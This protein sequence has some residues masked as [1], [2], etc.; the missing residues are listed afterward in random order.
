ML[1]RFFK[2]QPR[3]HALGFS[4]FNITERQ[5]MAV[6][7]SESSDLSGLFF[8]LMVY[9]EAAIA[10][11]SCFVVFE[12]NYPH[13]WRALTRLTNPFLQDIREKGGLYGFA[14]QC[15]EET[16][17]PAARD[18][19]PTWCPWHRCRPCRPSPNPDKNGQ[20]TCATPIGTSKMFFNSLPPKALH[21]PTPSR[22]R[23]FTHLSVHIYGGHSQQTPVP[24]RRRA[25][26]VI[27]MPPSSSLSHSCPFVVQNLPGIPRR[28]A[29]LCVLCVLCGYLSL[30][31]DLNPEP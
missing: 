5:S 28:P 27:A 30:S 24:N 29:V 8:R 14:V 13:T 4:P 11:S 21:R 25:G 23:P 26:D 20:Y 2:G 16:N 31:S 19:C 12:P 7:G 6:G 1:R 3:C 17:T 9:M 10:E 15:D 22:N 18:R